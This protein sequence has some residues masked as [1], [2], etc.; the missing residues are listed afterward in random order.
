MYP[1]EFFVYMPKNTK[2]ME[3]VKKALSIVDRLCYNNYNIIRIPL[4]RHERNNYMIKKTAKKTRKRVIAL[5]MT[6]MILVS[7]LVVFASDGDTV[8]ILSVDVE[9][10]MTDTVNASGG[11]LASDKDKNIIV[12]LNNGE[13][14]SLNMDVKRTSFPIG[15]NSLRIVLVNDT[16]CESMTLEYMYKTDS[17]IQS[18]GS[19]VCEIIK[20]SG[21]VEYILPVEEVSNLTSMKLTFNG[22]LSG[23]ISL[24][25]ISPISY[26]H[27]GRTYVGEITKNECDVTSGRATLAGHID[28][29]TVSTNVGAKVVVYRLKHRQSLGSIRS[30]DDFIASCDISLD[31]SLSFSLKNSTDICSRYAVAVLNEDGSILPVTSEIYLSPTSSVYREDDPV[32]F[33]GVETDLYAGA[34]E[35]AS[36][37]AIVDVYLDRMINNGE[38]GLQYILDNEEYY[39]DSEYIAELD[40]QVRSYIKAGLHLWRNFQI[41]D[42][43]L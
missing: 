18:S 12:S 9:R 40:L 3:K 34:I 29:E 28:W 31:F 35:T 19:T 27:D 32:G 16:L 42:L 39:I 30:S 13:A 17:G 1:A 6:A 38:N 2:N 25:S 33:K 4:F 41:S 5:I 26:Y 15:S 10:F 11:S 24:M 7:N 20:G 23:E 22:A 36:S 37:V 43:C 14:T 8:R 21:A